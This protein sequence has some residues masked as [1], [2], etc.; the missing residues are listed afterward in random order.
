MPYKVPLENSHDPLYETMKAKA[1]HLAETVT[2]HTHITAAS[3]G[4]KD[5]WDMIMSDS[6]HERQFFF[7][8]MLDKVLTEPQRQ[9]L[10]DGLAKQYQGCAG[11]LDY[12]DR[13]NP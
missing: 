1:Y 2:A 4:Y 8:T 7:L 9:I 3:K 10:L 12:V 5:L 6:D 11:W 13:E